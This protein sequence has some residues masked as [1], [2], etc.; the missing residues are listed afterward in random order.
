[1]LAIHRGT[2]LGALTEVACSD[3]IDRAGG[4]LRSRAQFAVAAGQTYYLQAGGFRGATARPRR[5][6]CR[7][8]SSRPRRRRPTTASR[9]PRHRPLPFTSAVVDTRGAG[10]EAGEVLPIVRGRGRQER[11]V[12]YVAPANGALSADTLG[13]DFDTVLAVYRGGALGA[14]TEIACSDDADRAGGNLRSR[15]RVTVVAGQTYHLQAA[16][17]WDGEGARR[18]AEAPRVAPARRDHI[19]RPTA[20]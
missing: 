11:L 12:R 10:V 6:R 16:G 18:R 1:M 8:R 20:R 17:Y 9:A 5:A 4:N 13:S 2:A 14:L 7:S 15:L 3:D 19:R